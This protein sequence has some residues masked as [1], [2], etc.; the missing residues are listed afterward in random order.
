MLDFVTALTVPWANLVFPAALYLHWRKQKSAV[1]LQLDE[2][3]MDGL[4]GGGKLYSKG[5]AI[6]V[7]FV[8]MLVF[9]ACALGAVGEVSIPDLRGRIMIGCK[10]WILYEDDEFS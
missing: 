6:A 1:Q 2:P 7:L 5:A 8:G 3:L 10:G 4:Q 9:F